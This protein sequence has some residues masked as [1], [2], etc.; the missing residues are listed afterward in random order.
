MIVSGR[1]YQGGAGISS[2]NL[3]DVGPQDA[4]VLC[5]HH[6]FF[7][8]DWEIRTAQNKVP[9]PD[10]LAARQLRGMRER[11]NGI[12]HNEMDFESRTR[13]QE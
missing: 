4:K 2:N 1:N 9:A 11:L 12:M 7:R 13:Y 10:R 6:Q 8:F 5:N 3:V